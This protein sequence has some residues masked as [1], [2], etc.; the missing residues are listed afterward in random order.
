MHVLKQWPCL[1]CRA[2]A[3]SVAGSPVL[4]SPQMSLYARGKGK[5]EKSKKPLM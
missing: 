5:E 1:G 3:D 4:F 2:H